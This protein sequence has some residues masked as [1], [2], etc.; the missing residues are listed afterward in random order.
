MTRFTYHWR[1]TTDSDFADLLVDV[2]LAAAADFHIVDAVVGMEGDG[3][4]GRTKADGFP[5]G[6]Q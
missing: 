5:G 2:A 6:G 1:F 4:G 3:P